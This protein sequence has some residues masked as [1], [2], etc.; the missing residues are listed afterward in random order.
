[1]KDSQLTIPDAKKIVEL[2]AYEAL[3]N[4][5]CAVAIK[6]IYKLQKWTG[7]TIEQRIP[8]VKASVWRVYGQQSY[9]KNRSLH[10][11]AAFSWLSQ[12][13]MSAMYYGSKIQKF[14]PGVNKD[15]IETIVYS[16]LLPSDQFDYL[17]KQ[18]VLK[19]Q[20]KGFLHT[21]DII[22]QLN[23]VNTYN[24]ND[25]LMPNTLDINDF[26]YDYYRSVG[27]NLKKFRLANNLTIDTMA[28]VLNVSVS[29]Y[30]SFENPELPVSIP[31]HLG[32]RLKLGFNIENTVPFTDQMQQYKEFS[33]ARE[34]QQLRENV[35]I[36]L[37]TP[38]ESYLQESLKKMS[39]NVMKFHTS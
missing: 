27:I 39:L 18:L 1:V 30:E 34:I 15:I 9:D 7:K 28:Y 24:N 20:S 25:F 5:D 37:M 16:S 22:K 12:V 3:F 32:M 10:V 13:T 8:G 33:T 38:T 31:L 21:T 2:N 36:N 23:T 35:I 14:W 6:W 26:K 11:V 17:L 19:V 4:K 29:R